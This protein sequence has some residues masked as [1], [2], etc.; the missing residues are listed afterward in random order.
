MLYK[1]LQLTETTGRKPSSPF[2]LY[3]CE[4]RAS[5][6]EWELCLTLFSYPKFGK[7]VVVCTFFFLP[8]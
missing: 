6:Q 1:Y 8:W 4:S 3:I 5:T 2:S 7:K